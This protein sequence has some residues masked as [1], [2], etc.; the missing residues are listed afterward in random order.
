MAKPKKQEPRTF[1]HGGKTYVAIV[2]GKQAR[3]FVDG[4]GK[5]RLGPVRIDIHAL[6]SPLSIIPEKLTICLYT[7]DPRRAVSLAAEHLKRF[8]RNRNLAIKGFPKPQG[9]CDMEFLE[10]RDFAA[11]YRDAKREA[12]ASGDELCVLGPKDD[13]TGFHIIRRTKRIISHV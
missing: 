12:H 2:T 7:E 3:T 9:E 6:M 8:Y 4:R 13:P 1:K 10:D 5:R 11:L